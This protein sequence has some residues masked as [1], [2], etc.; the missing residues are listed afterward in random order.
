MTY[1]VIVIGA[2][3]AGLLGR[4]D[5]GGTRIADRAARKEPPA[6]RED[7]DVRRHALQSH[8]RD[9]QVGHRPGLSRAGELPAFGIGG[10]RPGGPGQ[11]DRGRG[12]ADEGRRDRQGL[13]R[14]QPGDGRA[15]GAPEAAR[16]KRCGTDAGV[17][18]GGN[19]A[20]GSH[21]SVRTAM[22]STVPVDAA[23]RRD[24][25]HRRRCPMRPR[26]TCL[27]AS[28]SPSAASRIPAAARPA[29][30]TPGQQA[31]GH[32]IV[33]PRPALV[34]L[35]TDA[36]WVRAI[37]GV[38]VPDVALRCP[39]AGGS[40][41]QRSHRCQ[42]QAARRAPR[43]AAVHPLRPLRARRHRHQPHGHRRCRS[44]G[45]LTLVCD[46]L[47]EMQADALDAE[48]RAAAAREGKRQHRRLART[49]AAAAAHRATCWCLLVCRRNCKGAELSKAGPSRLGSGDQS[50]ADFADRHARFC[51][52]GSDG[53]RRLAGRGRQPHDAE[54]ARRRAVLRRREFSIW[55]ARS[56]ATTFKRRLAPV[57]WRDCRCRRRCIATVASLSLVFVLPIGRPMD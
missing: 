35:T 5:G 53:R 51:Q 42:S 14:Q 19:S 7:P 54:Q 34:P 49:R 17:A 31:L 38:T 45:C 18:G 44:S 27:P 48:I 12:R 21:L 28:S 24:N 39:S 20:A 57:I 40:R 26:T 16:A 37:S 3:A 56:A 25:E 36:A 1:D 29:T 43:L 6:G 23:L 11:A 4:D 46:F 10:A 30:A 52:G 55:M 22:R 50:D 32:T 15:R 8:A 2:G 9:R 41:G 47:P 13:S 33:P